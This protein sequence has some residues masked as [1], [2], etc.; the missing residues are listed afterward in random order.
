MVDNQRSHDWDDAQDN[1]RYY[2]A[3]P[4]GSRLYLNVA[5]GSKYSDHYAF[6]KATQDPYV[7]K[8][9]RITGSDT[10]PEW[11][12]QARVDSHPVS[13]FFDRDTGDYTGEVLYGLGVEVPGFSDKRAL[14]RQQQREMLKRE[15]LRQRPRRSRSVGKRR[16][17]SF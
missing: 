14:E 2:V 4:D 10:A 3:R 12:L 6:A 13:S 7:F 17:R 8:R 5:K 16:P 1:A 11:E 9:L 15:E